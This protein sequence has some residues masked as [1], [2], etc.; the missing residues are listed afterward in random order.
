MLAKVVDESMK[1]TLSK[2]IK[3]WHK[4]KGVKFQVFEESLFLPSCPVIFDEG[5]LAC[6]DFYLG[7]AR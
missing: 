6:L 7:Q 1:V 3:H 4:R 5:R 2:K